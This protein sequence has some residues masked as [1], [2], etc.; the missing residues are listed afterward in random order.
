MAV[1]EDISKAF[2][3]IMID[4][5]FSLPVVFE[6]TPYDETTGDNFLAIFLLP[7]PT[8]QASLG[9]EGCDEHKGIFQIDIVYN[10][11]SGT[12]ELYQ[13][14]DEINA[15]IKSGA[16]FTNN[17]LNVRIGNVSIQRLTVSDGLATLNMS[18]DYWAFNKR[19]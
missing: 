7:S 15:I 16:T 19:V 13:K 9:D 1:F 6:N 18:I 12:H 17:T 11:Y 8:L 4:N 5:D 14:A 3:G 10:T 2:N